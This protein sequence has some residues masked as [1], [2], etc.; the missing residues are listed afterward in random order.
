[1]KI[2]SPSHGKSLII[3]TS[4]PQIIKQIQEQ[5]STPTKQINQVVTQQLLQTIAAQQKQILVQK[6]TNE[7]ADN[8]QEKIKVSFRNAE[9]L[10][11]MCKQI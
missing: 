6:Q 3:P 7:A 4:N 11:Y 8:S 5:R 9:I 10:F 2:L 1:M